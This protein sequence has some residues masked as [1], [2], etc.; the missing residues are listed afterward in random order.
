MGSAVTA[1]SSDVDV[2]VQKHAI[3]SPNFNPSLEIITHFLVCFT[4]I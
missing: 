3:I 1:V 4:F 2:W